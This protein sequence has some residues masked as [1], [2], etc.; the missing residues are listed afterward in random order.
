[1]APDPA[2]GSRN[3][4]KAEDERGG[5]GGT[6]SGVGPPYILQQRAPQCPSPDPNSPLANWF[7]A[8]SL[9]GSAPHI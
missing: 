9:R 5:L 3:A 4:V 6:P 8:G 1:M 2:P 7:S